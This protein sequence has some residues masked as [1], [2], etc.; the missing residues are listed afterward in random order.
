MRAPKLTILSMAY[1]IGRLILS[2]ALIVP[3]LQWK[4][5][6]AK[7]A[8]KRELVRNGIPEELADNL[9]NTYNSGNKNLLRTVSRR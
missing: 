2:L 5:W 6:K 9:T 1:Y 4:T 8:F 3:Y 7:S